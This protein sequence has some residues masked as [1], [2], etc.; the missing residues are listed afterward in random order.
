M[1]FFYS[2]LQRVDEDSASDRGQ[3]EWRAGLKWHMVKDKAE[4]AAKSPARQDLTSPIE[5]AHYFKSNGKPSK[6][7][8]RGLTRHLCFAFAQISQ[9]QCSDQR[10][11]APSGC[12]EAR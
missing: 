5:L 1:S 11:E 8:I 3:C 12:R 4:E 7:L 10:G 9:P 2:L 6:I